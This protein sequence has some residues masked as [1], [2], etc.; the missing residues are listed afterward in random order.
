MRLSTITS[1]AAL[2]A[3]PFEAAATKPSA[4]NADNC[5]RGVRA[6]KYL[7][8]ALTDCSSYFGST[9]ITPATMSVSHSTRSVYWA[10]YEQNLHR[11]S[12]PNRYSQH[13][14]HFVDHCNY[15]IYRN[16]DGNYWC[17]Y[18]SSSSCSTLSHYTKLCFA[19]FR[20]STLLKCM[21]MLR[22]L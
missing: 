8:R 6:S 11:Y 19:M 16:D 17:R 21:L 20:G 14:R 18:R 7:A 2:I 12:N 3:F 22:C 13:D 15:N 5:L 1:L 10:N 9:T 4:C